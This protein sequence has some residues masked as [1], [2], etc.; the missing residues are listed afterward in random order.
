[1]EKGVMSEKREKILL[2]FL[3]TG[4]YEQT[5]YV[6]NPEQSG[7][8]ESRIEEGPFAAVCM[9]RVWQPDKIIVF[10]T[11]EA[12]RANGEKLGK[13]ASGF[14]LEWV[15]IPEG[16]NK[17]EL[18][19]IFQRIGEDIPAESVVVVDVTHSFR[20]IPIIGVAALHYVSFVRKVKI[21]HIWYGAYS[22]NQSGPFP[23]IDLRIFS[24]IIDWLWAV[25]VFE[26]TGETK[27]LAK[28]IGPYQKELYKQYQKDPKVGSVA[29]SLERLGPLIAGVQVPALQEQ[30][31]NAYE[32]LQ[33]AL[34]EGK[35][36]EIAPLLPEVIV[37]VEKRLKQLEV[38]GDNTIL[39]DKAFDH[40]EAQ[41]SLLLAYLEWNRPA[42]AIILF[43]E[44]LVNIALYILEEDKGIA[45]EREE[46]KEAVELRRGAEAL[47][48]LGKAL[49]LER[50]KA[51]KFHQICSIW[52]EIIQ[53]RNAIAHAGMNAEGYSNQALGETALKEILSKVQE[54]YDIL[55]RTKKLREE[56]LRLRKRSY[57]SQSLPALWTKLWAFCKAKLFTY[58][59]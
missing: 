42:Q 38:R 55:Q 10:S 16:K 46:I 9:A 30:A 39:K 28:V 33:E 18:L 37:S 31:A 6:F 20:S 11:S 14:R 15:N 40:L 43:R 54:A 26:E 19:Q 34:K 58:R 48:N 3:G 57:D 53:K 44:W 29:R 25:R 51:E 32:V 27:P 59:R 49:G 56:S 7:I 36:R 23:V 12:Q 2:T 1:M 41:Y 22:P 5:K 24:D 13:E 50:N 47:L 17:A 35:L 45:P 52:R 8:A 21:E 4:K